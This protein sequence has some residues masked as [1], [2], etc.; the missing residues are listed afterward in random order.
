MYVFNSL[1]QSFKYGLRKLIDLSYQQWRISIDRVWDK[2]T[3][4]NTRKD[5]FSQSRD[6]CQSDICSNDTYSLIFE[7]DCG[8]RFIVDVIVVVLTIVCSFPQYEIHKVLLILRG[9]VQNKVILYTKSDTYSYILNTCG[10][11]EELR[12]YYDRSM[13]Y[14]ELLNMPS[15]MFIFIQCWFLCDEFV[16]FYRT[17][18]GCFGVVCVWTSTNLWEE[19][20]LIRHFAMYFKTGYS[21]FFGRTRLIRLSV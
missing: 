11:K 19:E 1:I 13:Y 6:L 4:V 18:I 20:L 14:F 12:K 16:S 9:T 7:R 3:F 21:I 10:N 15:S 17:L 5:K 8:V 2:I